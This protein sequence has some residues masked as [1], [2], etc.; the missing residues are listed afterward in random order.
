MTVTVYIARPMGYREITEARQARIP[1]E[2]ISKMAGGFHLD[3]KENEIVHQHGKVYVPGY[4]KEVRGRRVVVRSQLR[5]LP[6]GGKSEFD[7]V[8][9]REST[10]LDRMKF[11]GAKGIRKVKG[12]FEFRSK[13]KEIKR[14]TGW[15][16]VY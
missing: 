13:G 15:K 3:E 16:L 14:K 9:Y 11:Y 8:Y 2:I 12:D 5:D 4:T 6:K 1:E 10:A 7:P